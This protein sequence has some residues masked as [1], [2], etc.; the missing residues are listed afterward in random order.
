MSSGDQ[1]C[2]CDFCC[3]EEAPIVASD[4]FLFRC[5]VKD[6]SYI[7]VEIIELNE[8]IRS[9]QKRIAK[10]AER[11][12]SV[13]LPSSPSRKGKGDNEKNNNGD[14]FSL[15][16]WRRDWSQFALHRSSSTSSIKTLPNSIIL[17]CSEKQTVSK[18]SL[19]EVFEEGSENEGERLKRRFTDQLA[20]VKKNGGDIVAL[21]TLHTMAEVAALLDALIHNSSTTL[22][23]MKVNCSESVTVS[24]QFLEKFRQDFMMLKCR[25]SHC[26]FMVPF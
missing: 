18:E 4:G 15:S 3:V 19:P 23:Q 21:E 14:I 13:S 24:Y 8:F 2:K 16:R 11:G 6:T 1:E 17:K 25:D 20:W 12:R 7:P 26:M 10:I 9:L 5:S 22:L